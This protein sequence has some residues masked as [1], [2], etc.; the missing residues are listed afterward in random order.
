MKRIGGQWRISLAIVLVLSPTAATANDGSSV[1]MAAIPTIA[2]FLALVVAVFACIAFRRRTLA[3]EA[4]L[5]SL[6]ERA[7]LQDAVAALRGEQAIIWPFAGAEEIAS[8]GLGSMLNI[9]AA[10]GGW[11]DAFRDLLNESDRISLERAVEELRQNRQDFSIAVKTRDG[12]RT[13]AVRGDSVVAGAVGAAVIL[14]GDRTADAGQIARLTT[15]SAELHQILDA[16][17][18]PVWLRDGKF[19]LKY[20]NSAYRAAVEAD[21]DTP[22]DQLPEIAAAV[23]AQAGG[24]ALAARARAAGTPQSEKRHVVMSGAR[25][26]VELV[27]APFGDSD[28]LAGFAIDLTQVEETEAELSRHVGGHEVILQNLGTAIAIYGPDQSL[29]FFNNAFLQLWELDEAWLRASP[30]MGEVL[31]KLREGRRLPEYADFP[32]FKEEQLTLFT[33]LIDPREEMIHL[34]DGNTLRSVAMPHPFGGLLMIWEDVTDALALERNYNTLIAVQR[35]TL[36]NLFEGVAVIGANGRLR[37]SNPAFGSMWQ[38]PSFELLNEPH[39]SEIVEQMAELLDP[40]DDWQAEKE[41]LISIMT[42][43]ETYTDRFE[44]SDGSVLDFARVPLPDGAVLL[45]YLD[46][47]ASINM[48]RALRERNEALETADR[49]KS[50]FIANVS[51]ELRTPLNTII[52][53]TEILAGKYFG[54]LNERQTEYSAGILES[55]NRLLMLIDDILDLATIEAGHMSLE[56]DS[57]DLKALLSSS[58]GLIRERA[59][60][61]SIELEDDCPDDIGTIIADE[62]RLKQAFFNILSNAVKFTPEGGNIKIAAERQDGN[63]VLTT[64]DSGIGISA[65]DQQRVFEKFERGSNAE[66]RRSGAGL[67]LSLVKSFVELHGGKV[68]LQSAADAGTEVICTLPVRAGSADLPH[69]ASA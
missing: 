69:K 2:L 28:D 36:D 68:E 38:I 26:R 3:A 37:L 54:D 67:G 41:R 64:S 48:E 20:V 62:R 33:T 13:F 29:Q 43:R 34:P 1:A 30:R 8:L 52:G 65:E 42:G 56:L 60:Q 16:L 39:I 35:E 23:G 10:P 59:R 45:S 22:Y 15:H 32:A 50:E 24:A 9:D 58:L 66:A 11:Y 40:V 46:V 53:F 25:R 14:I 47:T 57:I 51:Y 55:S 27:E 7:E 4:S 21:N 63:V 6:K 5:L 31:E 17:P 44:R 12:A 49:L 61:K 18:I 19:S